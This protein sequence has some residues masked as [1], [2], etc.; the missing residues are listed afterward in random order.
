MLKRTND[1]LTTTANVNLVEKNNTLVT[2]LSKRRSLKDIIRLPYYY[3]PPCPAC[4]NRMTGRFV[5]AHRAPDAE[6][7]ENMSLKNGELTMV[8][9]PGGKYNCFCALCGFTWNSPIYAKWFTLNE[10]G[11]EKIA[12]N[13]D[14]ILREK[15]NDEIEK[16]KRRKPIISTIAGFF[17]RF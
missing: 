8:Y 1:K 15:K 9:P 14:R 2:F 13:I 11:E 6:Y 17:G 16:H 4:G 10:I 12:R 3:V 5:K 7:I